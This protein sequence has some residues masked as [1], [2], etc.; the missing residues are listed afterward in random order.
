[1]RDHRPATLRARLHGCRVPL[2]PVEL[3]ELLLAEPSAHNGIAYHCVIVWTLR[4]WAFTSPGL[5]ARGAGPRPTHSLQTG[6]TARTSRSCSAGFLAPRPSRRSMRSA[7]HAFAP[8]PEHR[9]APP[10]PCGPP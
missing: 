7:G 2:E 4:R 1:M 8:R 5:A 10:R 3:V 6:G 9:P